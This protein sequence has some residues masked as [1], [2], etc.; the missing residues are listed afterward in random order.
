[1]PIDRLY[2]FRM[3]PYRLVEDGRTGS[4]SGFGRQREKEETI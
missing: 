2:L 3:R 4:V 1:M